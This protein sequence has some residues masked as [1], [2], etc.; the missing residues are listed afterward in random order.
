MVTGGRQ[1]KTLSQRLIRMPCNATR[2]IHHKVVLQ[3]ISLGV[4]VEFFAR[5]LCL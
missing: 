5:H 4:H 3:V 1:E 2:I